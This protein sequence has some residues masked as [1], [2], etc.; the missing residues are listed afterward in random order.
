[1]DNSENQHVSAIDGIDNYVVSDD[2]APHT[3]AKILGA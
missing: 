3:D 2:M 1:M